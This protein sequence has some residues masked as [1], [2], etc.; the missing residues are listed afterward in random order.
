[1]LS[2]SVAPVL[3]ITLAFCVFL[4]SRFAD[5]PV[6]YVGAHTTG[7]TYTNVRDSIFIGET[8]NKGEP[9]THTFH[10]K[11]FQHLPKFLRPKHHFD[12]SIAKGRP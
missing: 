1:M 4:S 2:I 11:M 3:N 12:R 5:S 8:D 10:D 7:G 6:S 9:Y